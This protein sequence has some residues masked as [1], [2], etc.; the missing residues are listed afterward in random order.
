MTHSFSIERADASRDYPL[1]FK[2]A[3]GAT[4]RNFVSRAEI[5]FDYD[6]HVGRTLPAS[7]V[8]YID[9]VAR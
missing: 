2:C 6:L 7:L 4:G 1:H 5:E 3:C 9:S 8:T